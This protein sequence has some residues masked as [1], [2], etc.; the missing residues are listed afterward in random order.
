MIVYANGRRPAAR[1]PSRPS[2]ATLSAPGPPVRAA[3]LMSPNDFD[4]VTLTRP[5]VLVC[6]RAIVAGRPAGRLALVGA[7]CCCRCVLLRLINWR[8][9][10][11]QLG[12]LGQSFDEKDPGS[13]PLCASGDSLS[14]AARPTGRRTSSSLSLG[15]LAS[16]FVSEARKGGQAFAFIRRVERAQAARVR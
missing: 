7:C 8:F 1:P 16:Y 15:R 12:Q 3:K 13:S 11:G 14:R 5:I 4:S 10:L 6:V 9:Q 2:S